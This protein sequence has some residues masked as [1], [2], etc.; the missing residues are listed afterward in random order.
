LHTDLV[1]SI[2][3]L[4]EIGGGAAKLN[5]TVFSFKTP[6]EAS[7]FNGCEGATVTLTSSLT[8]AFSPEDAGMEVVE[9]QEEERVEAVEWRAEGEDRGM[10]LS[11]GPDMVLA[12]SSASTPPDSPPTPTPSPPPFSLSISSLVDACRSVSTCKE[13]YRVLYMYIHVHKL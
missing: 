9:S 10:G 11:V 4:M 1:K 6:V 13:K 3:F 8:P 2:F 7:P 12:P 5:H